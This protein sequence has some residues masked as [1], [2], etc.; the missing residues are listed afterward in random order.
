MVLAGNEHLTGDA[1]MFW[2]THLPGGVT[3]ELKLWLKERVDEIQIL[4]HNVCRLDRSRRMW[5]ELSEKL[6]VLDPTNPW[7]RN[8]DG[9]YFD[10]QVMILTKI[11]NA[12]GKGKRR[13]ASLR[14]ALDEFRGRPELLGP[15]TGVW[16]PQDLQV[17]FDPEVDTQ[18]L[19]RLLRPLLPWRDRVVAHIELDVDLPDLAWETLDEA[20]DGVIEIFRRYSLRLTGV[21]YQVAHEGPQWQAWQQVFSEP[22]FPKKP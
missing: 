8:Y 13:K 3:E 1:I 11:V 6:N 5:N 9:L 20:I 22:I 18:E 7:A 16:A 2:T 17:A 4:W 19:K 15:L 12:G 10:T 21:A 14:I